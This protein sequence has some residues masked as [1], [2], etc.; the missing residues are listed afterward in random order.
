MRGVFSF[1]FGFADCN[2]LMMFWLPGGFHDGQPCRDWLG[3]S[4]TEHMSSSMHPTA[5]VA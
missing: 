3:G 1:C 2:L 4:F 5:L